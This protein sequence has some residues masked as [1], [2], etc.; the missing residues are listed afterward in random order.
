M[1]HWIA[2]VEVAS[3]VHQHSLVALQY[4]RCSLFDCQQPPW[5][6]HWIAMVDVARLV[7]QHSLVALQ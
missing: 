5:M 4:P 7:Q 6:A 1:A 3:L 2:M